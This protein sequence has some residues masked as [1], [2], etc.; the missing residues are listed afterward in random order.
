MNQLTRLFCFSIVASAIFTL[1]CMAADEVSEA[2]KR[3]LLT[4]IND[5]GYYCGRVIG[6]WQF[7]TDE[8]G[9]QI[10]VVCPGDTTDGTRFAYR[11][12]PGLR[13]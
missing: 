10:R 13:A 12:M 6:A 4:F 3:E 7:G 2:T 9:I 11:S 1:P 5:A 8:Y